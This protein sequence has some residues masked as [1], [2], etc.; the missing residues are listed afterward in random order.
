MY[1]RA[2]SRANLRFKFAASRHLRDFLKPC[3]ATGNAQLVPSNI[4]SR[5]LRRMLCSDASA[6][7]V[8]T[9]GILQNIAKGYRV[10]VIMRGPSGSGK[11]RLAHSIIDQSRIGDY[12][13]HIFS[14]D[15]FFYD[16]Q[17][18]RYTFEAGLLDAVHRKNKLRVRERAQVGWSPIIV[19]NTHTQLWELLPYARY[20]F[21]HG[22]LISLLAANTP[23]A[24]CADELA[25]RN[26]KGVPKETIAKMIDRYQDTS[27]DELL[28]RLN[29]FH[30]PEVPM[31]RKY[32][33]IG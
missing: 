13:D 33:P 32:P 2:Y 9:A 21:S 20:G 29:L 23:W 7:H 1:V 25:A 15:D 4:A 26:N 11:T 30:I 14:T 27:V 12:R 6:Q 5:A 24:G 19:D 18:E 16:P 3:C 31:L 8:E 17:T 22:Y 10:M 28:R